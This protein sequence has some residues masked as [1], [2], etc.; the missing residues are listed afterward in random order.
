M[1]LVQVIINN[2]VKVTVGALLVALFG[3]IAMVNMPKQLTPEVE[4][5]VILVRT[6][7][8]GA[9]P[10]EVE[11]EIVLEQEEQLKSVEGMIK[12]SSE[13]SDSYASISLEFAVGT[14]IHEAI[15]HVSTRLQQVRE[16]PVDAQEPVIE[17]RNSS[18]RSIARLVLTARPPT[19]EQVRIFVAE[20]PQL[21]EPMKPV[22][23]AM[24]PALMVYRL[25]QVYAEL[26]EQFP[27]LDKLMPPNIDVMKLRRFTEDVIEARLERIDGVSDVYVYGGLQ[28]ELQVVV[29]PE[30]LA[31]RRLTVANVREALQGQNKDTSAGDIWQGKRRYV[32]RTL[33]QFRSPEQVESL[34]LAVRNQVPI[35]LRDVAEVRIG[36]KKPDSVSRRYGEPN[37]GLG[38]QRRI[39]ANVMDVMKDLRAAVVELNDGVLRQRKLELYQYYD[40]TEY[41]SS[42]ISLVTNNI[43]L[44]TAMTM[45][46]LLMFLHRSLKTLLSIPLIVASAIAAIA[47]SPWFFL[48]TLALIVLVG[49]WFGRGA[50]VVGLAI[51]TSVVGTFLVLGLIGRSLNV[52]SLAGMAFAVGMLVD[53]AVVVLENIHR[54][55]Q[56]GENSFTAAVRGTSE[57]WGAVLASTLTTVAVFLPVVFVEDVSGQLFRDIALAI[58]FAVIFSLLVSSTLIPTAAARLYRGHEQGESQPGAEGEALESLGRFGTRFVNLVVDTNRWIQA[59]T[60]RSLATIGLILVAAVLL[61]YL[62]WPKVEYLPS[63]NRNFVFMQISPPPGYNM[64][65]LMKMGEEIEQELEV[66]WNTDPGSPE[67]EKLTSPIVSY[68]FFVVFGRRVFMG[69]RAHDPTRVAELIP[70]LK[71]IGARFPGTRVIASQSSLFERGLSGGRTIDIEITG[72]ELPELIEVGRKVMAR[73]ATGGEKGAELVPGAQKMPRPSLDLSSP[74]IHLEPRMVEATELGVTAADLGYTVDVLVDGAYA[75]DYYV[76]G[77]KLDITIKGRESLDLRTQD[78]ADLP[79]ATPSGQLVPLSLL[80]DI[81]Y[82]SG[83]EQINRRE[84]LRAITIQ[85]IPPPEI[86]LEE[87]MERIE[88]HV[89]RPLEED[90]TLGDGYMITLSG[91]ADKLRQTWHALRWNLLLALLITYLLMAALFESWLYPLVI[92]LSV[93]LGAV[94]GLLGLRLLNVFVLQPLDV[95]TMLGFVILIGTVVNNAILIVHQSLNHIRNE[96]LSHRE[97]IPLSV[98]SRVRPIFITTTTTVLGLMPLVVVPGAGSELYRGLGSV[99]LGGLL[100]STFFTL[101]LVPT[102]FTVTMDA[103]LALERWWRRSGA[104]EGEL[105]TPLAGEMTADVELPEEAELADEVEMPGEVV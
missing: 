100:V 78:L 65:E 20:H 52:I 26:G 77:N 41:I 90:G 73:L 103:R 61:S 99:V 82:S 4:N 76:G 48:L 24:N 56:L 67:A 11:R 64:E 18:D 62:F 71:E 92:I 2:P 35:Y 85:V 43:F 19:K 84:R 16:Y 68:Y 34:I 37:N 98:R 44:A 8:P 25:R 101:I 88:E 47:I 60:R 36:F 96:G 3:S 30:Q 59:R 72:S 95:L 12:M 89:I 105:A 94:G 87:A 28:E 63:G 70:R 80:A 46:I 17:T 45:M 22:L 81:S 86:A 33:G 104:G 5:P 91:A 21:A 1:N 55:C 6:R 79:V 39:G 74:E 83:P 29:D 93:P 57:V 51:P 49:L 40:E 31:A 75:G 9:S 15:V 97:A 53:N 58:S 14:N 13:C 10:Q 102:V 69:C 54:R 50:L 23:S 42:A 66:N 38:I 7:W 27:Q 32:I